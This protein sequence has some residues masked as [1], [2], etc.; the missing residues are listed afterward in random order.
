MWGYIYMPEFEEL[1]FT[2]LWRQVK[3]KNNQAPL[4]NDEI[5]ASNHIM[6]VAKYYKPAVYFKILC[7][8]ILQYFYAFKALF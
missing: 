6:I 5:V 1:N 2:I 7:N 4:S 8:S 3:N